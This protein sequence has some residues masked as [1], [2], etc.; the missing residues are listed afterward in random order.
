SFLFF[1][2]SF[3]FSSRLFSYLHSFPTRRSSDLFHLRDSYCI[4]PS[5]RILL[6]IPLLFLLALLFDRQVSLLNLSI[7][8]SVLLVLLFLLLLLLYFLY[9]FLFFFLFLLYQYNLISF[10]FFL[11]FCLLLCYC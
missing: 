3:F 7:H 6:L 4:L 11:V 1:F 5:H 10:L 9:F 2:F 8:F